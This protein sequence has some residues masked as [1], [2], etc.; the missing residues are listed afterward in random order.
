[1]YVCVYVYK[2]TQINKMQL[3]VDFLRSYWEHI[4]NITVSFD[5]KGGTMGATAMGFDDTCLSQIGS[6]SHVGTNISGDVRGIQ[7]QPP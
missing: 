3:F 1:M 7:D 6:I 5:R 4:V 2:C